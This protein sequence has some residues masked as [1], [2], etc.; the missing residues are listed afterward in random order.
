MTSNG[1]TACNLSA[2]GPIIHPDAGVLAMKPICPHTLSNRSI[3]FRHDVQRTLASDAQHAVAILMSATRLRLVQ[4]RDYA[5]FSVM[6]TK[7]KWSGGF[8]ERSR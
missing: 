7:L 6:R 1:S 3:I 4:S 5:H 8:T 2:G